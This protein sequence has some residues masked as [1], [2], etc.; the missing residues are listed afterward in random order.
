M[1]WCAPRAGRT[2]VVA[3]RSVLLALVR[4]TED[5]RNRRHAAP[6]RA[7]CTP[8]VGLPR[9]KRAILFRRNLHASVSG[10]PGSGYLQLRVTLQHDAD[11]LAASL[12]RNLRSKHS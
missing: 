7:A 10:R 8:G 6:T 3:N 11:R 5:V 9:D 4:D 1:V 2:N 12:L